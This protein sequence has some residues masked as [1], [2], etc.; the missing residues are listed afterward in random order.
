MFEKLLSMEHVLHGRVLDIKSAVAK[1]EIEEDPGVFEENLNIKRTPSKISAYSNNKDKKIFP[2]NGNSKYCKKFSKVSTES[3]DYPGDWVPMGNIMTSQQQQQ[4]QQMQMMG[5]MPNSQQKPGAYPNCYGYS[6]NRLNSKASNF[7]P[8]N[9]QSPQIM[10]QP[11][12]YGSPAGFAPMNMPP[13]QFMS[14]VHVPP[15]MPPQY[16]QV[17]SAKMN[18]SPQIYYQQGQPGLFQM[19]QQ[20]QQHLAMIGQFGPNQVSIMESSQVEGPL[21]NCPPA[22]IEK[23]DFLR[24]QSL[25]PEPSAGKK[26]HMN[27][28]RFDGDETGGR[29]VE[30]PAF[31]R[32]QSMPVREEGP[33][34]SHYA[35]F[36]KRQQ[37]TDFEL[38]LLK[39]DSFKKTSS[40]IYMHQSAVQ[41]KDFALDAQM[42]SCLITAHK[43]ISRMSSGEISYS[44]KHRLRSLWSK[45]ATS[46]TSSKE[47]LIISP[48]ELPGKD[49]L[50][51]PANLAYDSPNFSMKA[52][53]LPVGQRDLASPLIRNGKTS[54]FLQFSNYSEK[55]QSQKDSIGSFSIREDKNSAPVQ[56]FAVGHTKPKMTLITKGLAQ[57]HQPKSTFNNGLSKKC[58]FPD[59]DSLLSPTLIREIEDKEKLERRKELLQSSPN[60]KD[61]AGRMFDIPSDQCPENGRTQMQTQEK[62]FIN[63]EEKRL[64]LGID[65]NQSK[66]SEGP[67]QGDTSENS[68]SKDFSEEILR[69]PVLATLF[70][71]ELDSMSKT[72]SHQLSLGEVYNRTNSGPDNPNL[73][74]GKINGLHKMDTIDEQIQ[75]RNST[76]A[77]KVGNLGTI[78][79]DGECEQRYHEEE[80]IIV[81]DLHVASPKRER[82][83]KKATC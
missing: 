19:N 50:K 42:K 16:Y 83:R 40:P 4:Q 8:R 2:K 78:R 35:D 68:S 59:I 57:G 23:N 43:D 47:T 73:L 70:Q 38:G 7:V 79:E 25:G 63:K 51:S 17:H 65:A 22:G 36:Y 18:T 24:Q 52:K 20:Q 14:S 31:N 55:F 75:R 49:S 33:Q 46:S 60:L 66:S 34:I 77:G 29:P 74:A 62:Y 44:D 48:L 82:L 71:H 54:H 3:R 1:E 27:S 15:G 37:I 58:S 45:D 13:G 28:H 30:R 72:D 67:G 64:I 9:F 26:S 69:N 41:G 5:Q 6:D 76:V 39:G 53:R 32:Q 12:R 61:L 81:Q 56:K 10:N 11:V 80:L 21:V